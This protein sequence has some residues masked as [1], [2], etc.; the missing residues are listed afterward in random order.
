MS[1][2]YL[3]TTAKKNTWKFDRPVLFL[4]K[5]AT[6][7]SKRKYWKD[8]DHVVLPYHWDDRNKL[9]KDYKYS[10]R[11]MNDL[12]PVISQTLNKVHQLDKN[13]KYWRMIIGPWLGQF[14]QVMLDRWSSIKQ[15]FS[16]YE[17][18]GTTILKSNSKEIVAGN[19]E[20]FRSMIEGDT[21]NHYIY[22]EI[23]KFRGLLSQKQ[24]NYKY[25]SSN[26]K[27]NNI[28]NFSN[29]SIIHRLFSKVNYHLTKR[30]KFFFVDYAVNGKRQ[31]ILELLL[32]QLTNIQPTPLLPISTKSELNDSL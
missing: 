11:L 31:I 22:S 8:I 19:M 18:N 26:S 21:W 25:D 2:K 20:D 14:I 28:T 5:W 27:K 12:I 10:I 7:Y 17:I 4:G 3:I 15:A 13:E 16:Q 32:G 1:S 9:L 24:I 30:N 29:N 23:I 6:L